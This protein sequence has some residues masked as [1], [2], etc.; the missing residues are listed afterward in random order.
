MKQVNGR[1]VHPMTMIIFMLVAS[2]V[3]SPFF[4]FFNGVS[5]LGWGDVMYIGLMGVAYFSSSYFMIKSY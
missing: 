3:L 2:V 4:I 1:N 5:A